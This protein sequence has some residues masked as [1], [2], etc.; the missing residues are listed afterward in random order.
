MV[1]RN[2]YSLTTVIEPPITE[3]MGK[4][5]F[6]N[7]N[8]NTWLTFHCPS[9]PQH[10]GAGADGTG[11]S[12]QSPGSC[13]ED[14]RPSPFVECHGTGTCNY[15]ATSLSYWLASIDRGS[16]FHKPIPMTLKAG[17]LLSAISRCQVCMRDVNSTSEFRQNFRFRG[18]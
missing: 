16:Q 8:S 11:Q 2:H 10:T 17:N 15:Y 4:C 5:T 13:L 6:D 14:F 3:I 9:Y 7:N 1:S 18:S 12:L